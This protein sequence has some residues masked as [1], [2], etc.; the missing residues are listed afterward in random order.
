MLRSR[1]NHPQGAI[2]FEIRDSA[3]QPGC[4]S[5]PHVL[6]SPNPTGLQ[7][8]GFGGI[9]FPAASRPPDGLDGVTDE[10]RASIDHSFLLYYNVYSVCVKGMYVNFDTNAIPYKRN[11][12]N[13]P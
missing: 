11:P 3:P 9:P 6:R 4:D 10:P 5:E 1:D 12:T 7:P 13:T 2:M 8:A